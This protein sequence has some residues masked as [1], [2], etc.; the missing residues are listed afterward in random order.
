MV[1]RVP[2]RTSTRKPIR[3]STSIVEF[4]TA[5]RRVSWATAQ[6]GQKSL[7]TVVVDFANKKF[8]WSY[9]TGK[10]YLPIA[11]GL[12]SIRDDFQLI[13]PK[14]TPSGDFVFSVKG[15]TASAVVIMPNI[16]YRFDMVLSPQKV[17]YWGKHDGYPSYNIAVD[18]RSVYDYVQGFIGELAG[19]SDVTVPMKSVTLP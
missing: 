6:V 14:F 7:Q 11:G 18:H 16:N 13:G 4:E 12:R 3:T 17:T 8:S 15:E 9:K 19:D 2:I 5:I 10:T 1:D